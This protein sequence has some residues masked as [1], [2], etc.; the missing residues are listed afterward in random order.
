[1][2]LH[3][4]STGCL[5]NETFENGIASPF[6]MR[7][8]GSDSHPHC[9]RCCNLHRS[10]DPKVSHSLGALQ[11]G[12]WPNKGEQESLGDHGASQAI[13]QG[14]RTCSASGK[15]LICWHGHPSPCEGW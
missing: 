10:S 4:P 13:V 1:M 14:T 12:K 6:M 11:I 9:P 5:L 7:S 15:R 8:L 2:I 3:C